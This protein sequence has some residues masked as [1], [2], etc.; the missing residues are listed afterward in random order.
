PFRGKQATLRV[1]SLGRKSRAFKLIYQDNAIKEAKT[2]YREKNRQQF[3]F[4]SRRGWNNGV[5][6]VLA[7]QSIRLELG[8]HD[9]G[10][11]GQ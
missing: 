5:P 8:Q 6:Y 9:M 4:S 3:H 11:Y 10:T 1:N 7:A 2:F